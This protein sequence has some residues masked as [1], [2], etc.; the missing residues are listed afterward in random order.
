[1]LCC[2]AHTSVDNCNRLQPA[3]QAKWSTSTGC[4]EGQYYMFKLYYMLIG[5]GSSKAVGAYQQSRNSYCAPIP[6]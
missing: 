3:I 4:E 2:S 1:M 6:G 5:A